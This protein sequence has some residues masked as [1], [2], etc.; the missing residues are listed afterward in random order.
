MAARAR[1]RSRRGRRTAAHRP[2]RG[3]RPEPARSDRPRGPPASAFLHLAR[4][5][6]A[7]P[8]S[9]GRPDDRRRRSAPGRRGPRPG[10]AARGAAG[11]PTRGAD[12][13]V[14]L[15]G[16]PVRRP[17][18]VG[19]D[20]RAVPR[21]R[22]RR[23]GPADRV[24]RHGADARA[25]V[26]LRGDD[27]RTLRPRRPGPHRGPR[28]PARWMWRPR[29][30][31]SPGRPP[32]SGTRRDRVDGGRRGLHQGGGRAVAGAAGVQRPGNGP[33]RDR[34]GPVRRPAAELRAR[35]RPRR[36]CR[37]RSASA[38]SR[39]GMRSRST[40]RSGPRRPGRPPPRPR[41]AIAAARAFVWED[42]GE[43]VALVA[44]SPAVA[45][46]PRI[47]PV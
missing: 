19:G 32:R 5:A 21:G 22:P 28:R 12:R 42:G 9:A 1:D 8:A 36:R 18:G 44:H 27:D 38:S 30:A 41:A 47:G 3:V 11:A 37:R 31:P 25:H 20:P 33:R 40:P 10:L 14:A 16:P 45:G 13:R 34:R 39:G 17:R 35:A 46:V 23:S 2:P 26:R 29:A 4:R 15:G 24:G 43:P 6:G 7:V